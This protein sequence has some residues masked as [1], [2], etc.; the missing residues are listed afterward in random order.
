[1]NPTGDKPMTQAEVMAQILY[2]VQQPQADKD[3]ED[4]FEVSQVINTQP[5]TQLSQQTVTTTHPG[6]RIPD[7]I[8]YIISQEYADILDAV[9][10]L[11]AVGR[12]IN[13][14]IS[15]AQGSGK[16]QLAKQY[17]AS[18]GRP[19]AVVEVGRLSEVNQIYGTMQAKGGDTYF[20]PGLFTQAIQ[21]PRCVL[22]LQ[23]INRPENDTSLNSLFS[24]L[25]DSSRSIWIDEIEQEVTVAEGVTIIATL[26]EGYEYVGTMPLDIALR[27]RFH[28][29][30][31]LSTLPSEQEQDLICLVTGINK[32]LSSK[33]VT[34]VNK[35]RQNVQTPITISTRDVVNIAFLVQLGGLSLESAIQATLGNNPGIMETLR[36]NT[37]LSGTSPVVV[38]SGY[39]YL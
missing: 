13:I 19:L 29:R 20:V 33:L 36:L 34:T 16:S 14:L 38:K 2:K 9:D 10:R 39:K 8:A 4:L 17:A 15:G 27:N 23:E 11:T 21:T 32:T 26:N 1:M 5:L 22:H 31:E 7:P 12:R 35:M 18:R 3:V 37:Q 24:V 25:D 28:I 6:I 30:L